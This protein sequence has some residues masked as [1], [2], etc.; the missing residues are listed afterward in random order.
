MIRSLLSHSSAL[1][2]AICATTFA[3]AA[4]AREEYLPLVRAY[5]DAMIRDGRDTCGRDH[6]PL[7]AAALD[8]RTMKPGTAK[9]FGSIDGVRESDRSPGGANPQIDTALYKIL[10][11]LTELTGDPRYGREA[12]RA[13]GFFFNRCQSPATGLMAWGEHLYWDFETETCK[14]DDSKHEVCGEWPFWDSCYAF[15]P[16]ACWKF[17]IGQ[18]DH[19]IADKRTGDFS[20]H[21]R[22]SKHGPQK[23][24]DFPRYA[25][26]MI[27]TWADAHARPENAR[28]ERRA[29]LIE[30]ITVVLARMENNMRHTPTGYLPALA[31]ADYLWPTSNLEL[32]RCLWKAAP[33]LDRDQQALAARMRV[34][35]LRQDENFFRAPHE[36]ARG[37]GFAVTLDTRTGQPRDRSMNKPYTVT[38]ASGYGYGTHAGVAVCCFERARQLQPTHPDLA[39]RYR[40]LALAATKPYLTSEPESDELQKPEVFATLIEFFLAAHE[41]TGDR[42]FLDRAAHFAR[43]GVGLFIDKSSPLPKASNRHDHYETITGGPDFMKALLQLHRSLSRPAPPAPMSPAIGTINNTSP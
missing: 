24:S 1:S 15:A 7:F 8:R 29:E 12:D 41:L 40:S 25:G 3:P 11:D 38:W 35:A 14:G 16:E 39:S 22:Y 20:R 28:R 21:A 23:D 4:P 42:K 30:A 6:S 18:W 19:Q 5:A 37:G 36:I 34:L 43:V 13:L 17:A 32:A 31:G 26:Q 9:S 27:L 2:L 33:L 10:H